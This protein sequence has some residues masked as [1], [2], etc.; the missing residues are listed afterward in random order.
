MGTPEFAVPSLR[1]IH[2]SRH[3]I[4]GIV[5]QP[6]RP[7][8]RGQKLIPTPVKQA[9]L[10]LGLGPVLQ[11]EKL[12]E[13]DFLAALQALN[14][15][16][17]AVVAFRIMP[18]AV[19]AM[20]PQGTVNLHP[21]A[22][23]KYRGAAP[24]HWTV[25]NGDSQTA[26]TTIFIQREIDAGNII[27]QEPRPVYPEDTT[28]DLHDRLSED[29]AQLLVKSLDLIAAGEVVPQRQ[30]NS[31]ATP[32][33]KLTREDCLLSFDQPARAVRNRIMGLS[34]FPGAYTFLGDQVLKL[35]RA[36]VIAEN[37]QAGKPGT[38]LRAAG[39]QI[40]IACNPGTVSILECQLQG[41]KRL[42]AETFLRGTP[43]AEGQ[44]LGNGENEKR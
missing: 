28:G 23:P 17:F 19:F 31:L 42:D 10:E 18:E 26:I 36:R 27:L 6:D 37:E 16:L 44:V 39:D 1:A 34:P 15:D 5:S 41:R 30:D 40:L 24:L 38:V 13:P 14:A 3:Q 25:L 21:S 33:R 2:A 12:R 43:L 20:P 8:G 9:A 32:A 7:K 11:P 22:L 4:V 29:G 35:Y